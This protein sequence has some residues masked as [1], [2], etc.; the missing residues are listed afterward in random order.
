MSLVTNR[1]YAVSYNHA[2]INRVESA[3]RELAYRLN[4][5]GCIVLAATKTDWAMEDIYTVV[6]MERYRK[7]IATIRSALTILPTT[8]QTPD[9]MRFLTWAQANDI[10][11]ILVDVEWLLDRMPFAF[12]HSGTSFSGQGGLIR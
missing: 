5:A 6:D 1:T 11:R 9:S 12:R 2:D 10:E 7:N 3:V 4:A 8:P